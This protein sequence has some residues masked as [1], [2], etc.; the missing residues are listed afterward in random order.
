MLFPSIKEEFQQGQDVINESEAFEDLQI[1]TKYLSKI[2]E[3]QFTEHS[4]NYELDGMC[5]FYDKQK[6]HDISI[7]MGFD[8]GQAAVL[9]E[10][11]FELA[12][13][14]QESCINLLKIIDV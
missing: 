2:A 9:S 12:G 3:M 7:H 13:Q 4:K 6:L 10:E 5:E 14:L 11:V 1:L 8:G